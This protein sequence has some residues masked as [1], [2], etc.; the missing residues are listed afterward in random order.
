MLC[1]FYFFCLLISFSPVLMAQ[2]PCTFPGQTPAT[3]LTICGNSTYSQSPLMNCYNNSFFVPG[4]TNQNTSYGDNNP[5]YYKFTCNRSGTFA[6]VVMPWKPSDD[7]NWQLFDITGKNPDNIYRDK[8]LSVAGNWSGTLGPTGASSTGVS[9]I[10]CRSFPIY[11]DKN[12]FSAM[13]QLIAGHTYL[14]MIGSADASGSFAL[15]VGGG[16]AD[17]TDNVDQKINATVTSCSNNEVILTFSKKINCS[18]IASDG[19][20]FSIFPA[21]T[22]ISGISGIGC[23]NN[24]QTDSIRIS[25]TSPLP[26]GSYTLFIKNGTDNNTLAD[27]CKNYVPA[28]T[29]LK[30]NILPFATVDT[31]ITTCKPAQLTAKFS[32]EVLCNSIATDGSDFIITGP[33]PVTVTA[34][35]FDCA[36]DGFTSSFSLILQQPIK[37]AGNYNVTIK[38]GNDGNTFV[39]ACQNVTPV[40]TSYALQIKDDVNADFTFTVKE[41]CIAD[42][43]LFNHSGGNGINS[44]NWSFQNSVS[45]HPQQ[46][47]IYSTGGNQ[48]ATL[49]VSNGVC[50]DTSQQN[51]LLNQK[52]KT[53]FTFPGN[54]CADEP[55]SFVNQ[56]KN[57][58]AW[59]WD[60]GNGLTSTMEQPASQLYPL[61]STD[62]KYIITLTAKNLNCSATQ[63]KSILIKNNC[64]I[65]VPSAFTPNDDGLN[66]EFGPI[67]AFAEKNILFKIFNRYGQLVFTYT[68]S[69]TTWNGKLN[70]LPQPDGEYIWILSYTNPTTGNIVNRKGTVFLIR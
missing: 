11:G 70:G 24:S 38:N 56:T 41:G 60:F 69:N 59:L 3:A 34:V 1:K 42:T 6:F 33:Q 62:K 45:V 30:M 63:T 22:T 48:T 31:I 27:V 10:Q 8:T 32:K 14:L 49:I 61:L 36:A 58:T 26:D 64:L 25:F 35:N 57:A 68:S 46:Q 23:N 20:D 37:N 47:V 17:I 43:V 67:N 7:Y 15:T 29:Q 21:S 13:P 53:D 2:L 65:T 39:S 44:W 50:N 9:F 51:F 40:G 55:V 5:I 28:G 66:D 4:C 16:T 12:T 54:S 19:S 18:S 52:L